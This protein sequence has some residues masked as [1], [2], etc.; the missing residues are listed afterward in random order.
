MENKIRVL[1]SLKLHPRAVSTIE[2][3]LEIYGNKVTSINLI[4][5]GGG[6]FEFHLNDQLLFSKKE[7]GRHTEDG[8]I[9]K[10][11]EE[12]LG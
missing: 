12:D 11:I 1:C 5:S 6:V 4:P 10:L 2:D 9:L 8:E 7:L 3:I